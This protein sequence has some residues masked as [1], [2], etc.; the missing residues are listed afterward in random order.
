MCC[1]ASG[2]LSEDK[3]VLERRLC[4]WDQR[5]IEHLFSVFCDE[6]QR[7]ASFLFHKYGFCFII[8][9]I[10]GKARECHVHHGDQEGNENEQQVIP[11]RNWS[12]ELQFRDSHDDK[13]NSLKTAIITK[14]MNRMLKPKCFIE[15]LKAERE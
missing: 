5:R 6:G 3:S 1:R 11:N 4:G 10:R 15:A 7:S 13:N 12:L 8:I 9:V 14:A 2:S